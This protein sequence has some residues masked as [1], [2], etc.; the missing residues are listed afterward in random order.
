MKCAYCNLESNET[1]NSKTLFNENNLL[2]YFT[3]EKEIK[4]ICKDCLQLNNVK[5]TRCSC[6]KNFEY[7]FTHSDDKCRECYL[8]VNDIDDCYVDWEYKPDPKM[9]C[10]ENENRQNVLFMGIELEAADADSYENVKKIKQYLLKD[11]DFNGGNKYGYNNFWNKPDCS[12]PSRSCEIVSTACSLNYHLNNPQW[13]KLLDKMISYG[14]KSND[15]R[16]CGIHIHINRSYLTTEEIHKLDAFVNLYSR[17]FRRF[18][19]RRSD[20]ARYNVNKRIDELGNNNYDDRYSALN[21]RNENTIE[22]RIFR[23]NLKYSS[24]MAL[25]ELIQ[26]TCDFIKKSGVTLDFLYNHTD[27]CKRIFKKYLENC[28]FTYLPAYTEMCRVW[29]D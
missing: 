25:F 20:Y 2:E 29:R 3:V 13:N 21:F 1:I 18:A 19:R 12:L 24:I 23:G 9:L 4:Y 10:C 16:A 26:G 14:F 17:Y 8:K 15:V 7:Y 11:E 5:I 22:F 6:G 27:D 28:N